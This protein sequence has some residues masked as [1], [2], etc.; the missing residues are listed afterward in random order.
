[1]RE[2]KM[3]NVGDVLKELLAEVDPI[4][5]DIGI[6]NDSGELAGV[7]INPKAYD[8]FLRKVE[9]EEDRIDAES[10]SDFEKSGEK[11]Q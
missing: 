4:E 5:E 8:F 3:D 10:V 2:I 11:D 9:E 7:V 6:F 1:M